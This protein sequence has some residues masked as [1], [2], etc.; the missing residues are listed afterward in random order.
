MTDGTRTS[1]SERLKGSCLCGAV[2]FALVPPTHFCA[3]CHCTLCQR[4]H[5]ATYV[6]W[7]G[8]PAE[9]QLELIAGAE[10]LTSY[11][12]SALATRSFCSRCGSQ[13]FFRSERWPGEVHVAAVH[14]EQL[15]R[16]PS[17]RVYMNDAVDWDPVHD[18]LPR[19]GGVSGME[20]LPPAPAVAPKTDDRVP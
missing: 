11:K 6:T 15:D 2:R 9:K 1:A 18:D 12:S 4:A 20:P 16:L 8:V 17:G 3:H 5:G 13:L 14:L 10:L 19:F 7:I